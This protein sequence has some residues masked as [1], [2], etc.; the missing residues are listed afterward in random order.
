MERQF[1]YFGPGL[2]IGQTG[3]V[4]DQADCRIHSAEYAAGPFADICEQGLE[5][6]GCTIHGDP[7]GMYEVKSW[8]EAW[9]HRPVVEPSIVLAVRSSEGSSYWT[10]SDEWPKGKELER[11]WYLVSDVHP[12]IVESRFE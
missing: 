3:T 7:P 6:I 5:L 4:M 2:P 10:L 9:I 11:G 8:G 12:E 1:I